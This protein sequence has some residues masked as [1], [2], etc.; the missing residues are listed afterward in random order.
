MP[1]DKPNSERNSAHD[2]NFSL[3][4]G[5]C[6]TIICGLVD[7]RWRFRQRTDAATVFPCS[8]RLICFRPTLEQLP[9]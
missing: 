9:L 5:F 1:L 2:W 3:S 7:F 6:L 8:R 4:Q